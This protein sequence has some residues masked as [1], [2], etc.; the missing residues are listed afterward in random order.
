MM[1]LTQQLLPTSWVRRAGKPSTSQYPSEFSGCSQRH[2]R[3]RTDPGDRTFCLYACCSLE[4]KALAK[5][6]EGFFVESACSSEHL[7]E[8]LD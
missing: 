3:S 2:S 5:L 8:R 7:R 6:E 1:R 4:L